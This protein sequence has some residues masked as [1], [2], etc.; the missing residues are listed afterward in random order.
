MLVKDVLV[1]PIVTEKSTTSLGDDTYA[2]EVAP[3]AT[4][5]QVAEAV[6]RFYGVAVVGVRTVVVR[7]KTKRFGRHYGKRKNWKKAY[8]KLSPGDAINFFAG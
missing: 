3:V 4:K 2:F 7:G 5:P 6:S 1:R 8:V